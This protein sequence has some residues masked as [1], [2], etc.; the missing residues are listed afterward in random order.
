MTE[1]YINRE[2]IIRYTIFDYRQTGSNRKKQQAKGYDYLD[3]LWLR[4]FS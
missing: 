1:K 4:R 2:I 3:F